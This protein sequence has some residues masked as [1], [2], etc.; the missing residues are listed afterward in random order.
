MILLLRFL[1]SFPAIF[2]GASV[3]VSMLCRRLSRNDILLSVRKNCWSL[4]GEWDWKE[5]VGVTP[6]F[7]IGTMYPAREFSTIP[8]TLHCSQYTLLRRFRR[9]TV[10]SF[11]FDRPRNHPKGHYFET[12]DN[13]Q[14]AVTVS[15]EEGNSRR[16][17]T[18]AKVEGLRGEF[19]FVE[20]IGIAASS[21]IHIHQKLSKKIQKRSQ[22]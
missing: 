15:P 3:T 4:A 16:G 8:K 11:L 22:K 18:S 9:Q 12:I 6:T 19:I 13:T 1:E 5:H 2:F 17:G 10:T 20:T 21:E 14:S 7:C